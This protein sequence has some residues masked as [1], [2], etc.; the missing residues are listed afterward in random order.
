MRR[1]P[2]D[3]PQS[4]RSSRSQEDRLTDTTLFIRQPDDVFLVHGKPPFRADAPRARDRCGECTA[5]GPGRA[6]QHVA[7]RTAHCVGMRPSLLRGKRRARRWSAHAVPVLYKGGGADY[8][9]VVLKNLSPK[10][11]KN[12]M[13]LVTYSRDRNCTYFQML[14]PQRSSVHAFDSS[15]SPHFLTLSRPA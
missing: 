6:L 4:S 13:M 8:G 5:G 7:P 2:Y 15:S 14:R 1:Q 10:A 3:T 11:D 12:R 9:C